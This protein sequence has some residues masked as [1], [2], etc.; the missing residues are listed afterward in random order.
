MLMSVEEHK[1]GYKEKVKHLED[2]HNPS[3]HKD[4]RG[5]H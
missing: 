3:T 1:G 5:T 4:K 2:M